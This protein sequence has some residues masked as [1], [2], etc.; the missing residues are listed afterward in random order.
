M[1]EA[2]S[3]TAAALA[4]PFDDCWLVAELAAV[5]C[6][7][8]ANPGLEVALGPAYSLI[9]ILKVMGKP[10]MGS[11]AM[12]RDSFLTAVHRVSIPSLP[13]AAQGLDDLATK[14][15]R[16]AAGD[17]ITVTL[18]PATDGK[19]AALRRLLEKADLML[20]GPETLDAVTSLFPMAAI[21]KNLKSMGVW[22]MTA[23]HVTRQVPARGAPRP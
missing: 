8:A 16:Y 6:E 3:F 4:A 21:T 15:E 2:T 7:P 1:I 14:T 19:V 9:P 20:S 22:P 23:P 11:L 5:R 18:P 10:P 13:D 17:R 12:D